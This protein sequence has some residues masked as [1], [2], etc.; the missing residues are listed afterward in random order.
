M[1]ADYISSHRK[2]QENIKV[3]NLFKRGNLR[4]LVHHDMAGRGYDAPLAGVQINLRDFGA[5][6]TFLQTGISRVLRTCDISR[7]AE[8]W[9]RYPALNDVRAKLASKGKQEARIVEFIGFN[10]MPFYH[11]F[12]EEHNIGTLNRPTW[13]AIHRAL[14][15]G[16]KL[17]GIVRRAREKRHRETLCTAL[18]AVYRGRKVRRGNEPIGLPAIMTTSQNYSNVVP[19]DT[20]LTDGACSDST[21]RLSDIDTANGGLGMA[22]DDIEKAGCSTEPGSGGAEKEYSGGGEADSGGDDG[23][24]VVM[25]GD[26]IEMAGCGTEPGSSNSA[27]ECGGD[28]GADCGGDEAGD[29]ADD[30]GGGEVADGPTRSRRVLQSGKRTAS[31][32][33]DKTTPARRD[34]KRKKKKQRTANMAKKGVAVVFCTKSEKINIGWLPLRSPAFISESNMRDAV[35]EFMYDAINEGHLEDLLDKPPEWK[36]EPN[37]LE[38]TVGLDGRNSPICCLKLSDLPSNAMVLVRVADDGDA[39]GDDDDDKDYEQESKEPARLK[40]YRRKGKSEREDKK[41]LVEW[42]NGD[43]DSW[44]LESD[45][46]NWP[47][48]L[49]LIAEYKEREQAKAIEHKERAAAEKSCRSVSFVAM[50]TLRYDGKHHPKHCS[51]HKMQLDVKSFQPNDDLAIERSAARMRGMMEALHGQR[52]PLSL[53]A[54]AE[55]HLLELLRKLGPGQWFERVELGDKMFQEDEYY[56]AYFRPKM[57]D[58]PLGGEQQWLKTQLAT[59]FNNVERHPIMKEL[60]HDASPS[61]PADAGEA[62][63][64]F[65]TQGHRV[66]Y[67]MFQPAACGIASTAGSSAEGSIANPSSSALLSPAPTRLT[68]ARKRSSSDAYQRTMQVP[69]KARLAM[70]H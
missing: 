18:A 26:D 37:N 9:A 41:Y 16:E 46:Q 47:N 34:R 61:R 22:S 3:K 68:S 20:M 49:A 64:G 70:E 44:E 38:L 53:V 23:G 6:A 29:R 4:I 15:Y 65:K 21:E 39:G 33:G 12:R 66:Y 50:G 8:A 48:G 55:R 11:K 40:K 19:N 1:V 13:H 42:K 36:P 43:E 25:A 31:Q 14:L 45:I 2:P 54:V 5:H 60:D 62:S 28:G 69:R 24:D 56:N 67:C 35:V 32:S 51:S 30:P 59:M 17:K 58:E 63:I 57:P 10:N 52:K 27:N 7:A